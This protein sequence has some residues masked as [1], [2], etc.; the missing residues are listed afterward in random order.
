MTKFM[1]GGNDKMSNSG[2]S[3]VTKYRVFTLDYVIKKLI[4]YGEDQAEA[5][6]R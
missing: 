2:E 1:G 6:V 5:R 4:D 3:D